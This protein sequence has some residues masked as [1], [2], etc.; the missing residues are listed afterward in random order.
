[1][2]VVPYHQSVFPLK[3]PRMCSI[4]LQ[5]KRPDKGEWHHT[6]IFFGGEGEGEGS[7]LK[8]QKRIIKDHYLEDPL[9]K[10]IFLQ[11]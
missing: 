5:A 1:M 2:P 11:W 10:G 4:L 8:D 3:W 9:P 7:W 6:E